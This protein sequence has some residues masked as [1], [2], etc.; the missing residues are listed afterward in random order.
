MDNFK[1][2]ENSWHYKLVFGKRWDM[3]HDR[4]VAKSLMPN[5]FCAYWR[6]VVFASLPYI[7]GGFAMLV[8]LGML[9]YVFVTNPYEAA[10][11]FGGVLIAAAIII[12]L[13]IGASKIHERIKDKRSEKARAILNGEKLEEKQPGLLMTRILSWK[14]KIC[15]AVEYEK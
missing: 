12:S 1:V 11:G 4:Y 6:A 5:N 7:F 9:V 8:A 3:Y 2:N 13:I 14:K 10:M 15:P